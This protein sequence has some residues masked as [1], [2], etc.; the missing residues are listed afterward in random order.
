MSLW[1]LKLRELSY[2]RK[3]RIIIFYPLLRDSTAFLL[4]QWKDGIFYKGVEDLDF[5]EPWLLQQATFLRL[6]VNDSSI[7]SIVASKGYS[8]YYTMPLSYISMPSS[9]IRLSSRCLS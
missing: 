6:T 5:L 9:H 7:F 3:K 1:H 4:P 8:S 2:F